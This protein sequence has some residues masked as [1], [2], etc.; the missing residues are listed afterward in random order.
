VT[1]NVSIVTIPLFY[2]LNYNQKCN[3]WR[4]KKNVYMYST[5]I[6]FLL[7]FVWSN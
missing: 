3:F 2:Y 1:F 7:S 6:S 4:Y 5:F